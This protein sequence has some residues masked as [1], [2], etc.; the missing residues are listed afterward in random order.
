LLVM[1]RG[2]WLP[3]VSPVTLS[4]S[5]TRRDARRTRMALRVVRGRA[6]PPR[7]LGFIH[8][9]RGCGEP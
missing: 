1:H 5:I 3:A 4:N 9:L 2:R 7:D 8:T 6:V